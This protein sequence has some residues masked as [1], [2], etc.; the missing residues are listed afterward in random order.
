[1]ESNLENV[2]NTL[3]RKKDKEVVIEFLKTVRKYLP[4]SD[5]FSI[6]LWKSGIYEYILDRNG[7]AI[8]RIAEDEYLPYMSAYEKRM[9]Y[10]QLPDN[11]VNNLDWKG[12]L[13]QLRDIALEYAK[14]DKNFDKIAD[15]VNHV[16]LE[17]L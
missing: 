9:D 3:K 11:L 8:M 15:M 1:M 2:I 4:P 16:I 5:D 10:S 17:N 6:T 12:V 14:R 13:R 7:V